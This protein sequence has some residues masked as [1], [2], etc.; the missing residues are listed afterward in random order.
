MGM[1]MCWR[2]GCRLFSHNP[3]D[4]IRLYEACAV[5]GADLLASRYVK[6]VNVVNCNFLGRVLMSYF[7]LKYVR[8]VTGTK[9]NDATAG[10]VCHKS[11]VLMD[12]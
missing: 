11:E 6:G 7:V 2:D 8:L 3:K 10:F 1:T 5:D 9:V 4:L 12:H